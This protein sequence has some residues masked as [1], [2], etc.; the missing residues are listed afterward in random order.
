MSSVAEITLLNLGMK[1]TTIWK[2]YDISF[3][4]VELTITPFF[5]AL[6]NIQILQG[7]RGDSQECIPRGRI[8]ARGLAR[9]LQSFRGGYILAVTPAAL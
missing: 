3:F 4:Q 6:I 7:S 8:V 9:G 5:I 2:K 1:T